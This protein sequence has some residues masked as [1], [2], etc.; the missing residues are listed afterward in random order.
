MGPIAQKW[1]LAG[2]KR[3]MFVQAGRFVPNLIRVIVGLGE[4]FS[5]EAALCRQI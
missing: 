3:S 1:V 5:L 4:R 2:A